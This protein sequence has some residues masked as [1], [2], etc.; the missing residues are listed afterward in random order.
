VPKPLAVLLPWTF[1]QRQ[2]VSKYTK[3]LGE[4]GWDVMVCTYPALAMWVEQWSSR[5]ALTLVQHL[6]AELRRSGP[7]PVV[8]YVFSGA[9]KVGAVPLLQQ[10][11]W[12]PASCNTALRGWSRAWTSTY[13][14]RSAV[15]FIGCK[16]VAT[17]A[18]SSQ[19]PIQPLQQA[20]PPAPGA[21][22]AH[23][24]CDHSASKPPTPSP[25]PLPHRAA[26]RRSCPSWPHPPA[27]HRLWQLP[28]G[29]WQPAVQGPSWTHPPWTS[30][31][32][33]WVA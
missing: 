21:I 24:L 25:C 3:L 27:A 33:W 26:T 4:Q 17:A 11:H 30:P 6:D 9:A 32:T 8:F 20:F 28:W 16:P 29:A 10:P 15:I 5:N 31:A 22:P 7:R 14:R 19:G 13:T 23:L 12:R 18:A 2:H 1:A